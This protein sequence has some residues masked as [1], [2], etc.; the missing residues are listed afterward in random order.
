LARSLA[1]T[2]QHLHHAEWVHGNITSNNIYCFHKREHNELGLPSL[3]LRNA[4]LFGFQFTRL[5]DEY[6]DQ[7]MWST[8]DIM[9]NFYRHPDRQILPEEGGPKLPH[10]S[11]HDIY[12]LG[13][14]F[15][16]IGL[17]RTAEE[18]AKQMSHMPGQFNGQGR[19]FEAAGKL[20]KPYFIFLAEN[21][22]PEKMGDSYASVTL[23]CLNGDI[24]KLEDVDG[25]KV[26]L[27]LSNAFRLRVIEPLDRLLNVF[28]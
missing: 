6:S 13:V 27:T 25:A 16:E 28:G 9:D 22:L 1:V 21:F 5:D 14:V 10:K 12:S 11:V 15:L 26:E 23:I 17:G 18:L 2:L 3:Q 4:Y 8:L 7:R 24:K 19:D 20:A